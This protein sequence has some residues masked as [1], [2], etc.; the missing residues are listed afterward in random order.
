MNLNRW[1]PSLLS[2]ALPQCLPSPCFTR[3]CKHPLAFYL[4]TSDCSHA[5]A[6]VSHHLSKHA[7][8]QLHSFLPCTPARLPPHAS[9]PLRG[10]AQLHISRCRLCSHI[11]LPR[12]WKQEWW[13]RKKPSWQSSDSSLRHAGTVGHYCPSKGAGVIFCVHPHC[14]LNASYGSFGASQSPTERELFIAAAAS[15]QP[16]PATADP[17]SSVC[18]KLTPIP[19]L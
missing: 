3:Q 10:L 5:C 9:P 1:Q 18:A 7:V 8:L 19:F 14:L 13:D 11:W 15:L 16:R 17:C 6:S 12:C 2:P 4:P